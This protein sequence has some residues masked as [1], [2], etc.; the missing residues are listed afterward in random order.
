MQGKDKA[1]IKKQVLDEYYFKWSEL[2][3]VDIKPDYTFDVT[4]QGTIPAALICFLES[5]DYVDCLKLT[6]ALGGDADTLAAIAGPMAYAYYKEMPEELI[7]N[8]LEKLPMW[9]HKVNE[10][11][12]RYIQQK[13]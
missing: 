8:A 7:A 6:I 5:N 10:E 11:M 3:Y 2:S 9:M 1:F 12:D 4:C 13:K